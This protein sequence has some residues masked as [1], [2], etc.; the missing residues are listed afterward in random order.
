[1][2][3]LETVNVFGFLW[4]IN[5]FFL[6][7]M[8]IALHTNSGR[9]NLEWTCPLNKLRPAPLEVLQE[10]TEGFFSMGGGELYGQNE[11]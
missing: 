2:N 3:I 8:G 10:Q 5:F 6:L 9:L 11:S 1:M 7:F 4:P